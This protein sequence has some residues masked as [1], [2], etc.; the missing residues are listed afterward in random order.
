MGTDSDRTV[1]V[2]INRQT[3][4]TRGNDPERIGR[5]AAYLDERILEVA[6]RSGVADSLKVAVLTAL[7]VVDE[8]FSAN[9]E[10]KNLKEDVAQRSQKMIEALDSIESS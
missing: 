3:Y 10:L 4:H 9:D 7:S 5:L 2:S 1:A 8:Y 6:N